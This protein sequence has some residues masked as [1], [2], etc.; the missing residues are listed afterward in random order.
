MN[1]VEV[2]R[3]DGTA[4]AEDLPEYDFQAQL[5][6]DIDRSIREITLSQA[7]SDYPLDPG[8]PKGAA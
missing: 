1:D 7:P 6:A 3:I 4:Y 8:C 2:I 5:N